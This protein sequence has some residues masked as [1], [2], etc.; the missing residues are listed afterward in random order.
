MTASSSVDCRSEAWHLLSAARS[1]SGQGA[2]SA[3]YD[4]LGGAG[5][6]EG[7]RIKVTRQSFNSAS[8]TLLCPRQGKKQQTSLPAGSLM[9]PLLK[10]LESRRGVVSG[11]VSELDRNQGPCGGQKKLKPQSPL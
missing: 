2:L 5:G 7:L 11:S 4:C 10:S 6:K 8:Y 1:V 9:E 3:F